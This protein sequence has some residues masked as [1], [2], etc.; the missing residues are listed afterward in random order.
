MSFWLL[1]A[2][3]LVGFGVLL[4]IAARISQTYAV[5]EGR[6]ACACPV[7]GTPALATL[8]VWRAALSALRGRPSLQVTECSRWPDR[9]R[10][11]QACIAEVEGNCR[12]AAQFYADLA[13]E[14]GG[15]WFRRW[16]KRRQGRV[17]TH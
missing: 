6:H 4:F 14:T 12:L 9:A 5:Y 3:A 15:P 16:R 10:C 1:L 8:R 7:D 13:R 11:D 2:I 17:A